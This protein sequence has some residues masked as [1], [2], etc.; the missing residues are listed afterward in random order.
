MN[1]QTLV[2][3]LVFLA[4]MGMTLGVTLWLNRREGLQ[5]RVEQIG[6]DAAG[7][8]ADEGLEGNAQWHAR[9]VKAVGPVA[10]LSAPK[11]GWENSSLRVRF[12]QAG[13]REAS[14]PVVFFAAKTLLALGIPCCSCST[15]ASRSWRRAPMST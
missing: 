6:G 5:Q 12:M 10:K 1:Q 15:V 9:V 8:R 14:W 7:A 13:L 11:E 3:V 4:V 2:L